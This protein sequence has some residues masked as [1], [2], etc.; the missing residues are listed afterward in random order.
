MCVEEFVRLEIK[1]DDLLCR[2]RIAQLF[3]KKSINAVQRLQQ[4]K[5]G[6]ESYKIVTLQRLPFA[7]YC[8]NRY[9]VAIQM[10]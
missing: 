4:K 6:E 9:V 8:G 10:V 5:T 7:K 3:P 1:S 2:V